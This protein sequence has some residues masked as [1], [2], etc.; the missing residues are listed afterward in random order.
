[1]SASPSTKRCGALGVVG[2]TR[3]GSAP[4]ASGSSDHRTGS[5]DRSADHVVTAG[6]DRDVAHTGQPLDERAG[7]GVDRG[8]PRADDLH[9][10][11]PRRTR[12][13]PPAL[14][15]PRRPKCGADHPA[16]LVVAAATRPRVERRRTQ[17]RPRRDRT[18]HPSARPPAP[19]R[20]TRLREARRCGSPSRGERPVRERREVPTANRVEHGL[21]FVE[22]LAQVAV[23][24][25]HLRPRRGGRRPPAASATP[26]VARGR[27]FRSPRG[28]ARSRIRS[29]SPGV[30]SR[31]R[32]QPR[33]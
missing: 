16:L 32:S 31:C 17:G 33:R 29:S 6:A 11:E 12:R 27:A 9:G 20:P 7:D 25:P 13:C 23:H 2:G 1:M 19:P 18:V 28:A 10:T 5:S 15:T 26:L 14:S 30:T 22:V 21:P 4:A 24:Q 3:R 8:M